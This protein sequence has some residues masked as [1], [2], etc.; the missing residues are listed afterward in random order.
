M[1]KKLLTIVSLAITLVFIGIYT[2]LGNGINARGVDANNQFNK[3]FSSS[4][5][6]LSIYDGTL[7]PG[8]AVRDVA[9]APD[10][11]CATDLMIYVKTAATTEDD[12]VPSGFSVKAG[13]TPKGEVYTSGADTA[14]D[15]ATAND[16]TAYINPTAVFSSELLYNTNNVVI[17][18]QFIQQ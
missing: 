10:K 1:S 16:N 4:A 6:T 12:A 18:I 17:G 8:T 14:Y 5:D 13:T 15:R 2:V 3:I 7:V 9:S 11:V